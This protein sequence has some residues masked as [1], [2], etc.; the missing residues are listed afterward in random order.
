LFPRPRGLFNN[1]G[2]IDDEHVH[3]KML[4]PPPA[5]NEFTRIQE[6][7]KSI[8]QK[9]TKGFWGGK[10]MVLGLI[11]HCAIWDWK[12]KNRKEPVQSF[13]NLLRVNKAI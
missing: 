5:A 9:K 8:G 12:N 11:K 7:W 10:I 13:T 1:E 3:T 4:P 2:R 6:L